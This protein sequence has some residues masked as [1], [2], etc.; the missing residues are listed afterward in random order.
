MSEISLKLKPIVSQP[1]GQ[2]GE[3]RGQLPDKQREK[4]GDQIVHKSSYKED[5]EPGQH[6]ISSPSN[7]Q[8]QKT[9]ED[10]RKDQRFK[11]KPQSEVER[12]NRRS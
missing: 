1:R 11:A 2:I 12:T 7:Q 4:I 8:D 6:I 5:L 3:I 9:E 10:V